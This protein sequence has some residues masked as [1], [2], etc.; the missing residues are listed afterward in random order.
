MNYEFFFGIG[1][2]VLAVALAW[3]LLHN[4]RSAAARRVTQ[5]ATEALYHDPAHYEQRRQE[6]EKQ[7]PPGERRQK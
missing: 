4:R 3:A 2:L 1:T 7:L 5:E 6:L